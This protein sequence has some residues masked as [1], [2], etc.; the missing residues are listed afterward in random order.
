MILVKYF[1]IRA[2][3]TIPILKG[4]LGYAQARNRIAMG[5]VRLIL[6]K[7]ISHFPCKMVQMNQKLALIISPLAAGWL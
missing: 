4:A 3:L 5:A 1:N 6:W 2:A 7:R